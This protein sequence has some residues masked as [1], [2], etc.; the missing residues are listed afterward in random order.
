MTGRNTK[1]WKQKKLFLQTDVTTCG[2][3]FVLWGRG[4]MVGR[5]NLLNMA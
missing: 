2:S 5:I 3:G 1:L 4:T